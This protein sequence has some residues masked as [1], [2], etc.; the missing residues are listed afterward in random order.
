MEIKNGVQQDKTNRNRL[1]EYIEQKDYHSIQ[2]MVESGHVK[3]VLAEDLLFYSK[4]I[5]AMGKLLQVL[6]QID[7][8]INQIDDKVDIGGIAAEI[9]KASVN[10][11]SGILGSLLPFSPAALTSVVDIFRKIA[12]DKDTLASIFFHASENI[13]KDGVASILH[14][15]NSPLPG[16]ILRIYE[17]Y[18]IENG[19]KTNN[20]Q[21]IFSSFFK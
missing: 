19:N 15:Y 2:A 21:N 6:G 9:S 12:K 13:D 7:Y 4:T 17:H 3:F 20:S 18:V 11:D 14:E 5:K 8:Y 16:T 10:D 1:K